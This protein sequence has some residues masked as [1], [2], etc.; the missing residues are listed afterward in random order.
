MNAKRKNKPTNQPIIK[1]NYI[2]ARKFVLW[3]KNSGTVKRGKEEKK[4]DFD[5]NLFLILISEMTDA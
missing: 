4:G 1:R 3:N 2:L 5:W